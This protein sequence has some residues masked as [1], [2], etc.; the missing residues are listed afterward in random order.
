[1]GKFERSYAGGWL[2]FQKLLDFGVVL[3]HLVKGKVHEMLGKII[4]TEKYGTK[5]T[6][7]KDMITIGVITFQAFVLVE[8][9]DL[10]KTMIQAANQRAWPI[11]KFITVPVIFAL[12]ITLYAF[13][14]LKERTIELQEAR[15]I[16]EAANDAKSGFLANISHE[17]RTPL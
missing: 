4:F 8:V 5:T 1:M 7:F 3:L 6:T 9:L 15:K 14:R 2:R 12:A 16:A 10:G 11:D 13:D 17:L